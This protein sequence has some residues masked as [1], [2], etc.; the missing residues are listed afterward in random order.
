MAISPRS[1]YQ[2]MNWVNCV[3]TYSISLIF[4]CRPE[5]MTIT[6][7]ILLPRLMI[8][9]DRTC[10]PAVANFFGN[11]VTIL[12]GY[13]DGSFQAVPTF[14]TGNGPVSVAVGDFNRDGIV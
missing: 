9:G 10:E 4:S 14:V 12:L 1:I 5:I 2:N 8:P 3:T 11:N 7:C 6:R 13:G